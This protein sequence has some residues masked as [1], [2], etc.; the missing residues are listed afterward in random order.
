MQDK[1]QIIITD[2]QGGKIRLSQVINDCDLTL[3][4]PTYKNE[5]LA[6][7][8]KK[9][10]DHAGS[11][12]SSGPE[13][14]PI[15]GA[16]PAAGITGTLINHWNSA[17]S[18]GNH[19]TAGYLTTLA[20]NHNVANSTGTIQFSFGVNEAVR[21]EGLGNIAV[22]FSP[23]TKTVRITGDD[24]FVSAMT[25][26]NSTGNLTLNRTGGLPNLV[27][28]FDGRY[29]TSFVETD[30]I[31]LAKTINISQGPGIIVT[32]A[33]SQALL[34][35]PTY[36]IGVNS[37]YIRGLFSSGPSVFYDN[38][39]GVI[40]ALNN[41]P[42]SL[43][44]DASTGVLTMARN[45][46]SNL[47]V[48]MDGR[49]T[50]TFKVQEVVFTVG[51]VGMPAVGATTFTL[52][53]CTNNIVTNAKIKI[54]RERSCLIKTRDYTYNVSTGLVTLGVP[55]NANETL[56]IEIWPLILWQEC[57]MGGST[58]G[59]GGGGDFLM[60]NDS[61]AF[62]INGTDAILIN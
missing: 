28:N 31:A 58:G 21:F 6:S 26:D 53:D 4:V 52:K 44:W 5:S 14:D 17:F 32:G 13:V 2:K 18:W 46:L 16:S 1:R 8:L 45:G 7:I 42:T 40:G 41:F 25:F 11:G 50:R 38:T 57:N 27:A 39:T 29:M 30:A 43:A 24:K 33:A 23:S 61:D 34:L 37:T 9:M 56:V 20:H 35:N 15:F 12:G 49:Y 19:A 60:I 36:Q 62:L 51:D 59:G 10:C 54:Y 3:C 22:S 48:N 55:L 47:A